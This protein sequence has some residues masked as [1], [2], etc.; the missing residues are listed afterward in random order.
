MNQGMEVRVVLDGPV[1]VYRQIVDQ[2]R[3]LCVSGRLE[4]G[5][6]VPAARELAS[7]L[8][9]NHNT[10]AQAYRLLAEDGWVQVMPGRGVLVEYRDRPA[11]PDEAVQQREGDRLRHLVA[12]LRGKGL[13]DHWIVMQVAAA[14]EAQD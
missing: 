7:S 10:V 11:E 3:A 8:G 13:S 1:P 14:L 4:P 12:E 2:I 6:R 5:M 9:V